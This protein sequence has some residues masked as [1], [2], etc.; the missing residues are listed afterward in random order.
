MRVKIEKGIASGRIS[1]PPSK[2][3]AHRL[4]I[5]AALADGVSTVKRLSDCADVRATLDCLEALGIRYVKNGDDV[6]I[7]GTDVR[8]SRPTRELFCRESG[9]TL[10]F[11]APIAMLSGNETVLTGKESLM[12]RPLGVYE[13]LFS[14][15]GLK[16]ELS[17]TSLSVSGPLPSGEYSLPGNVSSQFITGLILALPLTGADSRIK[18]EPPIESRSYID[19]TLRAVNTFGIGAEWEDGHTIRIPAGR[20]TPCD[21]SVEGDWSG[22]AFPDALNLF[23]GDVDIEDLDEE[24]LQGDK[25]YRDH[26]KS[27]SV[28]TPTIDI[29]DCPDLGP[30]LFAAAA[31]KHGAHFTG[32]ARLKIKESDRAAAMRD[33][34][35]KLGARLEV[36]EDEV[37]VHASALTP[38]PVPL[39]GHNDHRIVMSLAILL[40]T[41]GGEITDAEAISKS[42]PDFFEDLISLGIGVYKYEA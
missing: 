4:L 14:E 26:F 41:L 2:S 10:R 8:K 7:F 17:G 11:L 21:I 12:Q 30:I 23:G 34:L 38:S 18:I 20:Y 19:L 25:V 28:G 16:F 31:A 37:V 6:K 39:F 1:A 33:E 13:K 32:T 27:L 15:R 24:S 42:Y 29:S 22:A 5:A 9:S 3:M 40:T 35:A 36:L